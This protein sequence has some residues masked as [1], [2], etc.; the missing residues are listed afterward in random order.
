[1]GPLDTEDFDLWMVDAFDSE[2]DMSSYLQC[3]FGCAEL[4]N[5][6]V[7]AIIKKLELNDTT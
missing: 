6:V 2:E 3:K 5:M 7:E 1:M 4:C